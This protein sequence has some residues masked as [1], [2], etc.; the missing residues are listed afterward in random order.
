M[1]LWKDSKLVVYLPETV[2][3]SEIRINEQAFLVKIGHPVCAGMRLVITPKRL[4]TMELDFGSD[5][6]ETQEV[7][8]VS[9]EAGLIEMEYCEIMITLTLDGESSTFFKLES[10]GEG[11][12]ETW[13]IKLTTPR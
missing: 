5:K 10:E 13:H 3:N 6:T 1:D 2:T 11:D 7:P 4:D 8:T 12:A 9:D